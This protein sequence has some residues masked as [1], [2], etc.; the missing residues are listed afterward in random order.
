MI[1]KGIIV[2]PDKERTL[3]ER[4]INGLYDLN[5]RTEAEHLYPRKFNKTLFFHLHNEIILLSEV[6]ESTR[7][8]PSE[9]KL[10]IPV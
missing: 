7:M 3:C 1:K 10:K 5:M 2:L 9:N 4:F 6:E 8:V